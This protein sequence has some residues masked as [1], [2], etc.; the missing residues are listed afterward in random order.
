MPFLTLG[1]KLLTFSLS[2][3]V[4]LSRGK[5]LKLRMLYQ[6]FNLIFDLP[7]DLVFAVVSGPVLDFWAFWVDQVT[8]A[9]IQHIVLQG[10]NF[11]DAFVGECHQVG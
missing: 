8:L 9:F 5:A 6:F 11:F 7:F 2:L 10:N 4:L 3:Y 1:I